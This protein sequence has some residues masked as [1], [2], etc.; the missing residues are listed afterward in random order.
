[1]EAP[2][3][4]SGGA[5][6]DELHDSNGGID[7]QESDSLCDDFI[8][9]TQEDIKP[10]IDPTSTSNSDEGLKIIPQ[11]VNIPDNFRCVDVSEIQD[12]KNCIDVGCDTLYGSWKSVIMMDM[13]LVTSDGNIS[14]RGD[15]FK[16]S[17]ALYHE[18]NVSSGV[19]PNS[20]YFD[21]KKYSPKDGFS[22]SN[23]QK[24]CVD[25]CK[26]TIDDGF[27]LV[28]NG[29]KNINKVRCQEF[30]CNRSFT[31][32]GK[33][34]NR[35]IEEYRGKSY[36]N[37]R[38]Q[39]RPLKGQSLPRM[40]CTCRPLSSVN[41]CK[42]RICISFDDIG[43]F[44]MSGCV[45][46]HSHH[47]QLN[48]SSIRF[49]SK[50]LSLENRRIVNDIVQTN[51]NHGVAVNVMKR[52]GALLN[53]NQ[54]RWLGGLCNDLKKSNGVYKADST[55]QM[56][57]YLDKKGYEYMCLTQDSEKRKLYNEMNLSQSATQEVDLPLSEQR[58][59]D[60]FVDEHRKLLEV[61]DD[62]K[63]MMGLAWVLPLE[64][65]LLN[66]F[67]EVIF[68][69]V[70]ADTNKE[71]RPLFTATAKDSNG[72]TFTFFRAFLPNQK[73]W[74]FRWIF[75]SVFMKFF[76]ESILSR[77][78]V[79]VSDECQQEFSQIDIAIKNGFPQALRVRCGFH[80][81]TLGW[82]TYV[83][84]KNGIEK[85]EHRFHEA[86]CSHLRLWIYSWMRSNCETELEYKISKLM[87]FRFLNTSEIK[88]R[89]GKPFISSVES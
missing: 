55:E 12:V 33:I 68:V 31:Y 80:M 69:D 10:D 64:K 13:T 11:F 71:E 59:C 56:L 17:S 72:K 34:E 48:K 84:N 39:N 87:F 41:R 42:F 70:I 28:K 76:G 82:K 81:V 37:D 78:Q 73:Q 30:V 58:S 60:K 5:D 20:V 40:T 65:E 63:L 75:S 86:V 7:H 47:P 1:M 21:V 4:L 77:V 8:E 57:E 89:L 2:S 24:L 25:L 29:F 38:K 85:K 61:R 62:Q 49:P 15:I 51:A 67:P 45:P 9:T 50:L 26:A 46:N 36:N 22:G 16:Y 44:V 23:F 6:K 88:A 35:R 32:R 66:L 83:L 74:V 19:L 43:F 27:M 14:E 79:I 18:E 3:L 53:R 52:R 54:I